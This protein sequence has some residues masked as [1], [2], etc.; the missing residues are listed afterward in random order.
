MNTPVTICTFL[1]TVSVAVLS[2]HLSSVSF[3]D[4]AGE[5]GLT[6]EFVCGGKITKDHIIE[7]LGSGVALLDY[8]NDGDLDAFFVNATTL[9]G[10]PE[11]EGPTSHLYRNEGNGY[12]SDLT[13]RAQLKRSGW[14][15]GVCTGDYD[16][17]GDT[18]L[19]VTYWGQ[20]V[21]YRNN[22]DGTF[23]DVS[24]KAGFKRSKRRWGTGCA[25]VD[26]DLDGRLD[27]FIANYVDFELE[28]AP[29]PGSC[30]WMGIP[31]LCGPRGLKGDTNQ[32]FHNQGNGRFKDVS[33]KSGIAGSGGSYSLSVTTLDAD[34]D[35]WP[36]IYVAVD[37]LASLLYHNNQDGT[38]AEIG[39][40]SGTALGEDGREQAGM[41]TAAGD[42]NGDGLLDLVK[43]NFS[44][45]TPNLYK[46]NGDLS[47][48]EL[49]VPAGLAVHTKFLGW[50]VVFL[51]YDND[52]WPDIFMVNGHVYP[53]VNTH[54]PDTTYKQRPILYRNLGNQR[55]KDVSSQ[56][57]SALM[58]KFAGRGLAKG[59]YD[60]DGDVDLFINNMWDSPSLLENRGGNGNNFLSVQLVGT[61]A[62]RS[63]IGGRV[64]VV[65]GGR[66]QMN[67]VRSGSSF[68]SQ[69]DLRLHFGLGQTNVVDR[70]EIQWP[71]GEIEEIV[72][73]KPN[74]FLTITQGKGITKRMRPNAK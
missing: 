8:D 39:L 17:D 61:A 3:V 43:T 47:F 51:D 44:H 32:L 62:N 27:L 26:H 28:T 18:D 11:T 60:N 6:A 59:D 2:S 37:S 42:F 12:F 53:E 38:F 69:N 41:G 63:G 72:S 24:E 30:L 33:V 29:Q 34:L 9:E 66:S 54:L 7:T 74:Q 45:D 64:T 25:F 50:G 68:M 4:V 40:L 49:T 56:A 23:T 22:A 19:F 48:S 16:N 46:N 36:D 52:T 20:N 13:E 71:G 55:F 31:V 67:E 57:G 35:G 15:Q 10:F 58:A 21:L 65:A 73:V 14:G 70:L 5:S 1:A